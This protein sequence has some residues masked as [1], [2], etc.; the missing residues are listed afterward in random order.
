MNAS[1]SSEVTRPFVPSATTT[2]TGDAPADS[3]FARIPIASWNW[4]DTAASTVTPGTAASS[5]LLRAF[6]DRVTDC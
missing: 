4:R 6:H 2:V 1:T 3:C 5:G